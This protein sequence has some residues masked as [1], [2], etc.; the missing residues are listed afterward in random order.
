M[1]PELVIFDCDGVL[2]D[3]ET[4]TNEVIAANLREYGLNLTARDCM[5]LFVGGT[6][7][8]VG[9]R[10]REMG[11]PLPDAWV[12]QIYVQMYARLRAGIDPVPGIGAVLDR[13][14]ATGVPYC[15]ASNG[16]EEKM[17]ITLGHT[18]MLPRFAGR[19]FSA[20]TVGVAKPEPDL[21]LTA[22][23]SQGIDPS[24]CVVI[25]DSATGATAAKRAGMVCYGYAIDGTGPALQ[26]AGAR[27]F[28]D[29]AHLPDLLGL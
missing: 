19:I 13:L 1:R 26:Q 27:V 6:M 5:A 12:D 16:T 29:M 10:A 7:A 17:Q 8:S 4:A 9:E 23:R 14:D 18:G 15:V 21:F 3:S 28:D 22:A 2:V 25:E 24:A 20:H 11:A